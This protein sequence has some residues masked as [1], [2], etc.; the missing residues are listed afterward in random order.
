MA[1]VDSAKKKLLSCSKLQEPPSTQEVNFSV[2]AATRQ[3]MLWEEKLDNLIFV[4]TW[5]M[6]LLIFVKK[7]D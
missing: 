4:E 3:N 5:R 6:R 1:S 2:A 7:I